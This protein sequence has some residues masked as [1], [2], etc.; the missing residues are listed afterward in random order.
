L[1]KGEAGEGPV[2]DEEDD[3][4]GTG[5]RVGEGN[6]F[7]PA[8]QRLRQGGHVRFDGEDFQAG[9]GEM[10]SDFDGGRFAQARPRQATAAPGPAA[11]RTWA[12]T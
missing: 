12:T 3:D 1:L 4:A 9:V 6:E 7:R 2:I 8:L 11:A 10:R 5:E